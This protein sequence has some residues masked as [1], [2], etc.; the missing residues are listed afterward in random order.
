MHLCGHWAQGAIPRFTKGYPITA[1]EIEYLCRQLDAD[2]GNWYAKRD[3]EKAPE[4][5]DT[6]HSK[7]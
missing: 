2:T 5:S 7:D 4:I 6:D 3:I 1:K